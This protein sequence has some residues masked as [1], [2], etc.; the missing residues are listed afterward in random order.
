MVQR[1]GL[2]FYGGLIGASL[3][4]ILYVWRRKLPL[5]KIADILAPSIALG[6]VFGRFGCF[7]NG[8]CFGRPCSLPWAVTYPAQLRYL[9][10]AGRGK[11]DHR[12]RPGHPA[13]SDANL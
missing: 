6:Y 5:W 11:V 13:A 8:C 10:N 2:V 9:G 7:L 4:C 3:A 1:G 12:K